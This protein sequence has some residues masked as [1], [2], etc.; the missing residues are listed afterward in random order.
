MSLYSSKKNSNPLTE[1][2]QEVE[3]GNKKFL[4]NI[5]NLNHLL[6]F[7]EAIPK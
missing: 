1:E 4:M 7:T 5:S 3:R 6:Y 2:K